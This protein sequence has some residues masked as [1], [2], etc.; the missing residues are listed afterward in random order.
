MKIM[1][2]LFLFIFCLL[3]IHNFSAQKWEKN[4]LNNLVVDKF[5]FQLF[6]FAPTKNMKIGSSRENKDF[7]TL[8]Y[9]N[10][11]ENQATCTILEAPK[12]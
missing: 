8:F 5:A 6:A 3:R 11:N 10:K 1:F 2:F 7:V 12:Q 9:K 4:V